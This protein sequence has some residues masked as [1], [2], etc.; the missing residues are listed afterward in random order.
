V[1]L[2]PFFLKGVAARPELNQSDGM[3]PT[4]K[5]VEVI[6]DNILPSVRRFIDAV[7]R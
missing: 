7:A 2:Y 6:V 5:G 1:P 4:A 3:H